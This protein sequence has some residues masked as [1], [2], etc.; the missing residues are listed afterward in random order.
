MT[1]AIETPIRRTRSKSRSESD[2]AIDASKLA[3]H[4]ASVNRLLNKIHEHVSPKFTA[5][6]RK[7]YGIGEEYGG[8][9]GTLRPKSMERVAMAL[10]G[11]PDARGNALDDYY[12]LKRGESVF[13]DI[14]SGTGRPTFYF[15]HFPIRASLGFDIDPAQ[16]LNS[17]QGYR[18]VRKHKL[19]A[20]PVA[21]FQADVTRVGDMNP[22]THVF[23]FLGYTKIVKSTAALIARS[24][25]VRVLVA[26][27]LH[28]AEIRGAGLLGDGDDDAVWLNGMQM[29]GG[30]SYRAVVLP[31]TSARRRRVIDMSGVSK[32]KKAVRLSDAYDLDAFEGEAE[33]RIEDHLD[34][35]RSSR[36][37]RTAAS[38]ARKRWLQV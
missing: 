16:V 14:G 20:C 10:M 15:A 31:M 3:C 38:A 26:V 13:C 19:L 2:D 6:E 37:R 28:D 1:P 4:V 33:K 22:V 21:L 5:K 25:T 27:V 35:P 18:V 11:T 34:T 32:P 29:P 36:K 17:L 30:N 23:A 12:H 24:S 8:I 7:K 9:T